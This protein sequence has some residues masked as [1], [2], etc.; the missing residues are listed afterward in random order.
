MRPSRGNM[1]LLVAL[2]T[3]VAA[4]V[5]SSVVVSSLSVPIQTV[6]LQ[7]ATIWTTRT[8]EQATTVPV[9]TTETITQF[10]TETSITQTIVHSTETWGIDSVLNNQILETV[11]GLINR[12][13]QNY[14]G[15]TL[16]YGSMRFGLK[17]L[18]LHQL[19]FEVNDKRTPYVFRIDSL[20][21]TQTQ[22]SWFVVLQGVTLSGFIRTGSDTAG[23]D[24]GYMG[25]IR[26]PRIEAEFPLLHSPTEH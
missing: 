12:A 7:E 19:T 9:Y 4:S 23:S 17:E 21:I 20:V 10:A 8:E 3:T 13:K 15:A 2:F 5:Y 11:Y 25:I 6:R 1:V 16:T 22:T 14:T 24:T 26:I 18:V